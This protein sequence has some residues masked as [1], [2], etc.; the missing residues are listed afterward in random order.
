MLLESAAVGLAITGYHVCEAPKPE[1]K[2]AKVS[3]EKY[4]EHFRQIRQAFG[5]KV[6]QAVVVLSTHNSI[7]KLADLPALPVSALREML[8]SNPRNYL[9]QDLP[10]H[11]FDCHVQKLQTHQPEIKPAE[12]T[13]PGAEGG[14]TARP[15]EKAPRGAKKL[16]TLVG[17]ARRDLLDR[18]F[19]AGKAA[20]LRFELALP[21]QMAQIQA[22]KTPL[23]GDLE[24]AVA[25]LDI[26]LEQSSIC[27]LTSGELAQNR[28]VNVGGNT[29][30]K[31]LAEAMKITHEAAESVK[32]LL[33]HTVDAKL[34]NLLSPLAHELKGSID[35]FEAQYEKKISVVFVSGG[36]ARSAFI[37]KMLEKQVQIPCKAWHLT[38]TV[39][40]S[41]APEQTQLFQRDLPQL[42]AAIGTGMDWLGAVPSTINLLANTLVEEKRRQRSPVRVALAISAFLFAL[43][44]IWSAVLAWHWKAEIGV[45]G[46]FQNQTTYKRAREAANYEALT[47]TNRVYIEMLSSQVADRFLVAPILDALQRCMVEDFVV[48]KVTLTRTRMK[49]TKG[50]GDKARERETMLV[51]IQAKDYS[52]LGATEAFIDSLNANPYFQR[53]LPGTD[54]VALKQRSMRQVDTANTSRSFALAT[55]EFVLLE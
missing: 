33:P 19:K 54:A 39:T 31:G 6:K 48:T 24:A 4:T 17:G 3:L 28:I 18:I 14:G 43:M 10:A 45:V 36:T 35:F 9:Q 27:I 15:A 52:E 47:Q 21:N 46:F 34:E 53:L 29:L 42:M 11:T 7:L 23:S 51:A 25:S 41:M 8:E 20:G 1:G 32:V 2:D 44:L 13:K 49:A 5:G 38:E 50:P 16:T 12:E 40:V 22:M 26:G 37:L 55:I 30:T